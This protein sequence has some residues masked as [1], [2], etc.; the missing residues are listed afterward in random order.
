MNSWA[1]QIVAK[2]AWM[3]A[4]DV[5]RNEFGAST[6]GYELHP[7]ISIDVLDA[8]EREK[9][10]EFPPMMREFWTVAGAGGAGPDDGVLGP[11]EVRDFRPTEAFTP[12]DELQRRGLIR[13]GLWDSP[14]TAEFEGE[15]ERE[16][17]SDRFES[18]VAFVRER[19]VDIP[20]P[21]MP[22]VPND[23]F[24]GSQEDI[25]G[26]IGVIEIG[27]GHMVAVATQEPCIDRM[28]S[29]GSEGGVWASEQTFAQLY[30]SWLDGLIANYVE[31]IATTKSGIDMSSLRHFETLLQWQ[32]VER[33]ASV[34]GIPRPMLRSGNERNAWTSEMFELFETLPPLVLPPIPKA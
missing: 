34:R 22:I 17:G 19:G 23:Y 11:R 24:E 26:L 25:T 5:N 6:H 31:L 28:F 4:V 12:L 7:P 9:G 18:L 29:V 13:M 27:C 15:H 1:N 20:M 32:A 33:L 21:K 10:Y 30:L 14:S 16:T 3:R 2:L 8:V